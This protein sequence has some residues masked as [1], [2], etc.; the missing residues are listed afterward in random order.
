MKLGKAWVSDFGSYNDLRFDFQET[1]LALVFGPTGSGKST[2]QDVAAWILFGVTAKNGNVDD[3]RSWNTAEPACGSIE[4]STPTGMIEVYRMRGTTKQNDLVWTEQDGTQKVRGKDLNDTQKLLEQRLGVT[5][6]QFL[7][8]A[9]YNESSP[10]AKFF[11]STA[12]ERRQ[13]LEQIVNLELPVKIAKGVQDAK[14]DVKASIKEKTR[15]YEFRRGR[16]A[17]LR[18]TERA[19]IEAK[20]Q[21]ARLQ[22]GVIAGLRGKRE[23]FESEKATRIASTQKNFDAFVRDSDRR[24]K[25]YSERMV[26]IEQSIVPDSAFELALQELESGARCA[27]CGELGASYHSEVARINRDRHQNNRLG[28]EYEKARRALEDTLSQD[29]PYEAQLEAAKAEINHYGDMLQKEVEK[30]NPHTRAVQAA[31]E[32]LVML[33]AQLKR[34]EQDLQDQQAR[35]SSLEQLNDLSLELRGTLLRKS[36]QDVQDS[37]NRYLE[38]FFDSEFKVAFKLPD[39]DTLEVSIQKNGYECVYRQL[40]KGQKGLLKLC[41]VVSIMKASANNAGMH[42]ENLFLDEAFDGFDTTLKTK[43]FSMLQELSIDHKN[44]LVI[45][46]FEDFKIMFDKQYKVE[47]VGDSSTIEEVHA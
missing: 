29:N 40:S 11:S 22:V 44:I 16:L 2:L 17:Q 14:K 18:E 20:D 13:V 9:Y 34:G 24:A 45:D 41:F 15:E 25:A 30:C 42:F 33:E 6:E 19:A 31:E 46:H 37:T 10:A 5:A 43:A 26:E 8:S 32:T 47:L 21:W 27:H 12:K 23:F 38:T 36:V 35:L 7:A 1:N 39:S 28:E 4:V 3:I